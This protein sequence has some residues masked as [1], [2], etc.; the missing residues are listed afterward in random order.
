MSS[1]KKVKKLKLELPTNNENNNGLKTKKH[2][3]NISKFKKAI[4]YQCTEIRKIIDKDITDSNYSEMEVWVNS[5]QD[6]IENCTED[7]IFIENKDRNFI[8][9][10]YLYNKLS[11]K[12]ETYKLM[13]EINLN[14]KKEQE[15]EKQLE[16]LQ[17]DM[18]SITTTI[19]AIILAI[20]I[21]PTAISGIQGMNK[22]YILP[23]IS[24]IIL[25]GMI[26][27][28]FTYNIYQDKIK[29]S[30][31][32]II[33]ITLIITIVL[34][35]SSIFFDFDLETKKELKNNETT[36]NIMNEEV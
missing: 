8:D 28:T 31:I 23:F 33:V 7:A 12:L 16:N 30:T 10:Q 27:I 1:Q 32:W 19:V 4:K 6:L 34:W 26:M 20:S 22:N 15:T 17:K 18:K 25:F 13:R 2:Q 35:L 36:N 29:K 5:S 24:S 14:K 3:D 11:L 9:L 21:I